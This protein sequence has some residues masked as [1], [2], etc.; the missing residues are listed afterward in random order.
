MLFFYPNKR[1]NIYWRSIAQTGKGIPLFVNK[2]L[3]NYANQISVA[4]SGV[5]M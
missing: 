3:F 2:Q 4:N 5:L 1:K